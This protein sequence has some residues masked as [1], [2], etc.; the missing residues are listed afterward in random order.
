[1]R[2]P[3]YSDRDIQKILRRNGFILQRQTGS[4][5]IYTNANGEHMTIRYHNCN[6]MVMRRMIKEYNLIVD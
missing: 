3:T 6:K 5:G 2:T 1:M 4:H